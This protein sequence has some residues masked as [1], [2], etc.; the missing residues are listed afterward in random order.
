MWTKTNVI[1]TPQPGVGAPR[2]PFRVECS[3]CPDFRLTGVE[4]LTAA[5]LAQRA[6]VRA[7]HPA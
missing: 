2:P 4:N 5:T 1:G 6:H 3:A 7:A